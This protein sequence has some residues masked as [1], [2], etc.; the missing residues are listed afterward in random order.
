MAL[1]YSDIHTVS[2][3]DANGS[4]I[5]IYTPSQEEKG[6]AEY[7][8]IVRKEEKGILETNGRMS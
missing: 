7:T 6:N 4:H 1:K 8:G 5:P 3:G 2:K